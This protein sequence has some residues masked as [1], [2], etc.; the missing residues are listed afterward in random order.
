MK[1]ILLPA[2]LLITTPALGAELQASSAR[3]SFEGT[4]TVQAW[5]CAAKTADTQISLREGEA[6]TLET[7]ATALQGGRVRIA[8]PALDCKNGTM[9][10]H[11]RVALKAKQHSAIVF[12]LQG[13]EARAATGAKVPVGLK[14]ELTLAGATRPIRL[15]VVAT[16]EGQTLR[17]RGEYALKMT[18]WN[19]TPP[20]LMFG[21]MKVGE[22]V[23]VKLDVTFPVGPLPVMVGSR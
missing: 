12:T 17:V 18:E 11:M 2:L 16:Q 13:A 23:T 4:S 15:E 22:S 7:V 3:V 5:T 19:I 20:T 10:D 14:G 21:T 9:N 8:V 6:L 1:R